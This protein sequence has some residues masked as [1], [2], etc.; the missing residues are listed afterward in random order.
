MEL[1]GVTPHPPRR[2]RVRG[3]LFHGELPFRA[4]YVSRPAPGLRGSRYATRHRIGTCRVCRREHDRPGA[5]LAYAQ[6]LAADGELVAEAR[7]DLA[8]RDLACWCPAGAP[9]HA[10]VLLLVAA[11][12]DPLAAA[13]SVLGPGRGQG[14]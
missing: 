6:D 5:V 11:G 2:V 3:D 10:D 7:R 13:R 9:C 12:R 4:I 14:A 1:P 8:G